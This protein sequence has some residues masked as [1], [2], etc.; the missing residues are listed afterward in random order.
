MQC[1]AL[2]VCQDPSY[3]EGLMQSL[4]AFTEVKKFPNANF[5]FYTLKHIIMCQHREKHY[6]H[7]PIKIM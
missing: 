3:L 4:K 2:Q 6:A 1:P 7:D 5:I